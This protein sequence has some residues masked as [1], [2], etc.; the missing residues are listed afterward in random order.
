MASIAGCAASILALSGG[1]TFADA[2]PSFYPGET[3]DVY[4]S[5]VQHASSISLFAESGQGFSNT[6]PVTYVGQIQ[7]NFT[8]TAFQNENISWGTTWNEYRFTMPSGGANNEAMGALLN[9]AKGGVIFTRFVGYPD[10]S[11]DAYGTHFTYL[12]SPPAGQ[13]PEVP[14]AALLPI[15]PLAG[16]GLW[17]LLRRRDAM[18][19]T[20]PPS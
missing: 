3:V 6:V 14:F 16:I 13:M 1:W 17:Y 9:T 10:V 11:Q 18:V 7:G 8:P 2:G 20:P 15:V 5:S 4:T 12:A 19:A